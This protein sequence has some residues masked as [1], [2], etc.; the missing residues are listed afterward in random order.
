MACTGFLIVFEYQTK[1]KNKK[2]TRGHLQ[3]IKSACNIRPVL[4]CNVFRLLSSL[5]PGIVFLIGFYPVLIVLVISR[6]KTAFKNGPIWRLKLFRILTLGPIKGLK[7][8]RLH[9]VKKAGSIFCTK[10]RRFSAPYFMP[11]RPCLKISNLYTSNS[12]PAS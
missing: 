4:A 2:P 10:K 5:N 6:V 1:G 7:I 3:A 9:V 11:C 8:K 12:F